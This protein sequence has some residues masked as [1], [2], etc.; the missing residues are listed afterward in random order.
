MHQGRPWGSMAAVR[1]ALAWV[2]LSEWPMGRWVGGW[3]VGG[4][5]APLT[6]STQ[7]T[8]K[9]KD[10]HTPREWGMGLNK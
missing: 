9:V 2:G 4:D 5:P 8:A 3:V 6:W 7:V 10:S 1:A